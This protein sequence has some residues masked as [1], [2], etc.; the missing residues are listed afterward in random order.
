MYKL[1]GRVA[2]PPAHDPGSVGVMKQSLTVV[3][4]REISRSLLAVVGIAAILF[5][6]SCSST[7]V[8][9]EPPPGIDL[10]DRLLSDTLGAAKR[11][12]GGGSFTRH[13][14]VVRNGVARDSVVL[15]APVTIRA[16][17][18][19]A[20]DGAT[21]EFLSTPVFNIGDGMQLDVFVTRNG[22]RRGVYS[23]YYDA[24]RKLED[25]A[26]IPVSIPLAPGDSAAGDYLE[27]RVGG[28]PQGDLVADWLALSMVRVVQ[29]QRRT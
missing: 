18:G 6:T 5:E 7:R 19:K 27:I 1:Q 9:S 20:A 25:R 22:K 23:R 8:A 13:F 14:K 10:Q 21:L 15:E 12:E 29:K 2:D 16:E 26:W 17:L 4:V 24:G 3:P 11:N 28:G